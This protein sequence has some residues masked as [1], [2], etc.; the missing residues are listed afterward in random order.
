MNTLCKRILMHAAAFCAVLALSVVAAKPGMAADAVRVGMIPDAGATQV[1]IEQK[2][3]LQDYLEKALGRSVRIIIPTN[4]N[5][6][7]E[8]LGNGSLDFAY[9]GGLTY[10]KAHARYQVVPVVQRQIDREFHSLFIA[11]A[12]SGIKSIKDLQGK[13]FA[14]GDI[15]STS[16]HL[17]AYRA[18]MKA[19]IDPDKDLSYRYTGSHTA[20]VQAVASGAADAG[21][22]DE[23]VFRA[24][25]ASGKIDK[26]SAYVFF[27]SPPFT[28][29]VWAARKDIDPKL[30]EKFARAF[31][32]LKEG[33]DDGI[34]DILRGK[35]FVKATDAEWDD[36]RA[37]A[38]QFSLF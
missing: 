12:G 37:V 22:V 18:M 16:G 30:Q 21:S 5:A 19:G 27:T 38:K 34:L 35:H 36:V 31:T 2:K 23:T 24:M 14:F 11:H 17:F 32:G 3:P 9:L 33:R 1:S 6:T 10:V 13:N 4:Y 7:V 29:Y 8:G 25:I 15:G 28:D 20:T 26:G